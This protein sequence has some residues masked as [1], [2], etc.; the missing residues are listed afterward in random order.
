MQKVSSKQNEAKATTGSIFKRWFY[1]N[2]QWLYRGGRPS[3]WTKI[4]NR[5]WAIVAAKSTLF[6]GLIFKG[7][8]DLEVIGRKSG[9]VISFPLVMV[10]IDGQRYLASMLGN[11]AQWVH[12]V[13]AAGGQ[14]VLRTG[15]NREE[16]QLAEVPVE[17]RAPL[18]KVYL[19]AAPGARPHVPVDKDAPLAEFE[20]IAADFPVFRLMSSQTT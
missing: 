12:N 2:K 3:R 10:T 9:R 1:R 5:A 8:V 13:R 19:K 18:L 6:N 15:G 20:K 7:L 16:V 11:E 17:Q 14:A 4:V